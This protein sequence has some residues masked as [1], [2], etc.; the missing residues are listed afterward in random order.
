MARWTRIAPGAAD[1]PRRLAVIGGRLEDGNAEIYGEMHRLSGGRILVFS[2]ASSEPTAV[3]AETLEVFHG[4]GFEAALAPLH[5]AAP[6]A[7]A[8]DAALAAMITTGAASISPAGTRR[9]SSRRWRRAAARPRR[10]RRSARASA[11]AG[12]WPGRAR[13]PR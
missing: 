4:H 7:G 3:G 6:G 12:C 9:R 2:T 5:D 11:R 1:A 8:D 13:A 10:S